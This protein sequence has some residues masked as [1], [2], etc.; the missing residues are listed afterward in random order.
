MDEYYTD[1]T[2]PRFERVSVAS[3]GETAT[4]EYAVGDE[5]SGLREVGCYL[6]EGRRIVGFR[7]ETLSGASADGSL[8]LPAGSADGYRV[9]VEDRAN[10]RAYEHGSL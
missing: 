2:V 3:D 9:Y 8:S 10:N 4:V 7:R 1:P 6:H 5:G